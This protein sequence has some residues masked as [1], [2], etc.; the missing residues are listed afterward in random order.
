[1]KVTL[2]PAQVGYLVKTIYPDTIDNPD[3]LNIW[4]DL[5]T[6]VQ[7]YFRTLPHG[8]ELYNQWFEE[9]ATLPNTCNL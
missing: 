5:C 6:E 4:L 7:E 2:S 9:W 3:I 1:M 8:E